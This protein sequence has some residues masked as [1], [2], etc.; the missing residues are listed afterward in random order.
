MNVPWA[1]PVSSKASFSSAAR[2]RVYKHFPHFPSLAG[3]GERPGMEADWEALAESPVT[4]VVVLF[5]LYGAFFALPA[6]LLAC[7]C[8]AAAKKGRLHHRLD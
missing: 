5:G 2:R 7:L 4:A 6:A 3:P 8:Q 1:E